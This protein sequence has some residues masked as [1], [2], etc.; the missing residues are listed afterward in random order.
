MSA[1]AGRFPSLEPLMNA[2]RLAAAD[3][4]AAHRSRRSELFRPYT[5]YAVISTTPCD[6]S[7]NP[8]TYNYKIATNVFYSMSVGGSQV[9]GVFLM[10]PGV[11]YY[12]NL[13]NRN[14][15]DQQSCPVGSTCNLSIDFGKP[16]GT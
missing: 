7:V 6:F 16:A 12:L 9:P 11:P 8:A 4:D 1:L 13:K 10:Q 5:R 3:H 14:Q 2:R 15:Y